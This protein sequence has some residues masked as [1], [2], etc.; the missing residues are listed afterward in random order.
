MIHTGS[1]PPTIKCE[2]GARIAIFRD[3]KEMGQIIKEHADLHGKDMKNEIET[4]KETER[5]EDLLIKQLFQYIL[6][7]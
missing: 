4:E 1:S 6:E 3:A 7:R 5:V 2:C